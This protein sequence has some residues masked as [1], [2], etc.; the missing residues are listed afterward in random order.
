[1]V[2]SPSV[3][4]AVGGDSPHLRGWIKCPLKILPTLKLY[5]SM[6]SARA[7]TVLGSF[8]EGGN[9]DKAPRDSQALNK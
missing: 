8:G 2:K 5:N 9:L 7:K 1:M 3:S 6:S 4:D